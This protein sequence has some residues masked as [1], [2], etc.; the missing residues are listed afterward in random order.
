MCILADFNFYIWSFR[1]RV[2]EKASNLGSSKRSKND[3]N[4]NKEEERDEMSSGIA[5]KLGWVKIDRG[6]NHG[7]FQGE[8]LGAN[9]IRCPASVG[10]LVN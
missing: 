6:A 2:L 5:P 3:E 1:R 8:T 4:E 7:W 9:C 10:K